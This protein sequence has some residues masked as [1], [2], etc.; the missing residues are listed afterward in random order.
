MSTPFG[1]LKT[2]PGAVSLA[3]V[4]K[5]LDKLKRLST[6]ALPADLFTSVPPKVLQTYRLRAAAGAAAR[7]AHAPRGYPLHAAWGVLLATSAGDHRRLG[8][9]PDPGDSPHLGS[10]R[11]AGRQRAA[12]RLS[13]RVHGKTALLYKLAEAALAQPDRTVRQIV[14]FSAGVL[15]CTGQIQCLSTAI[16]YGG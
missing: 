11:E 6:L 12:E 15:G 4:L 5:E 10:G 9:A 2:D 1:V 7:D 16:A 14:Y 13:S 8:R 3:S